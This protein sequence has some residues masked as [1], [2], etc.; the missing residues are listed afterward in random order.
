MRL[1]LKIFLWFWVAM[2]LIV[3]SLVLVTWWSTQNDP[4]RRQFQ[5]GLADSL[6]N[7]AQTAAQI[8]ENEGEKGLDEFLARLDNSDRI[9]VTGFY[10]DGTK[11]Y[12]EKLPAVTPSLIEKRLSSNA[13]EFSLTENET[14]GAEKITLKNGQTAILI[15]QWERF[16]LPPP[17][18]WKTLILQIIALILTTGFVCYLLARYLVAPVSKLQRAVKTFAD[19][20]LQTRIET[21]RRDELGQLA[22]DFNLMAERIESLISS[23]KTLNRDISHE[24]RTPLAR[25]GVALELARAKANNGTNPHLDRIELESYRLNEMIA[26]ILTLSKLETGAQNFQK[27]RVNLS[28]LVGEVVEDANFEASN[29]EKQVDILEN[30]A[31]FIEGNERLLQ[32][33]IENIVRNAVKYTIEKTNVEVSLKKENGTAEITVRDH[34]KGVEKSKLKDLFR[35]FYRAEE[36]RERKSGG[37]GLGLAITE[38][39]VTAYGGKVWAE[40]ASDNS[41]LIVKIELPLNSRNDG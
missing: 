8:Y 6:R 28:K 1:F 37:V 41:G 15:M 5:Q 10:L 25:L 34:G 26:Q 13:P 36:A 22:R 18:N 2:G 31:C 9:A 29:Q 39:A 33:A 24:L 4:I 23:Q 3:S 32:S 7:Q 21:K 30:Q 40:N 16:R 19:G 27:T 12:G 17:T 11:I 14:V 38:R 20:D 35:P